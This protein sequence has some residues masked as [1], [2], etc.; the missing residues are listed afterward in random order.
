[1]EELISAYI[2]YLKNE[3][4]ISLNTEMAYCRDLL[5]VAH[6]FEKKDLNNIAEITKRDM[7]EYMEDLKRQGVA[8][9]TILRK[10]AVIK[11]FFAYACNQGLMKEN[12]VND[13]VTPKV[14]RRTPKTADKGDIKKILSVKGKKT[15]KVLRDKAMIEL[16][17]STGIMVE[18]LVSLK[19]GD[20]NMKQGSI[21]VGEEDNKNSLEV[22]RH[23]MKTLEKYLKEGRP[24][25]VGTEKSEIL[26]PNM[27]G[28]PMSRQGFWKIL[29]TYADKAGIE[30]GITP[31]MV[32]HS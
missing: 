32:R 31:S 12:P 9:A 11:G 17:Y 5:K 26:F 29:K 24:V 15:P 30:G 21:Q 7:N 6:F 1:M 10:V 2:D 3:K 14:S 4:N 25:L 28:N 23:L 27:S 22:D 16:L 13:V 19:T 20:L 18:E 8:D